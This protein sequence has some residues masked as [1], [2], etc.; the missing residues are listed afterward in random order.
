MNFAN[1]SPADRLKVSGL[2]GLIVVIMF[3]VVQTMLGALSPKKP[4]PTANNTSPAAAP[5]TTPPAVETATVPSA[6][7]VGSQARTA[8]A[9]K[10]LRG[11]PLLDLDFHDP[12]EPAADV[13][14]KPSVTPAAARNTQPVVDILPSGRPDRFASPHGFASG[15][16]FPPL[17]A[18]GSSSQPPAAVAVV[19][20]PP[21]PEIQVV[22][23]IHGDPSVATLQVAGR[24]VLA[25]PGDL[26]AKGYR[27]MA[28]DQEGVVIRH[29]HER[30]TLRVGATINEPKP[31]K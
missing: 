28:V 24:I 15:G 13:K 1:L 2:I 18:F 9:E 19:P 12:F 14:S 6:P 5:G 20:P 25:R 10:G 16:S 17:P 30:V 4:A 29:E 22:G 3:V 26:L 11:D 23:V 27:L 8:D 31:G 21:E 7:A